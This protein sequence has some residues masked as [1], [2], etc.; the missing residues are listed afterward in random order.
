MQTKKG[1]RILVGV[2]LIVIAVLSFGY[3][4]QQKEVWFCDEIYTYES[5][6][7]FEQP[8]PATLTDRWQTGASVESYFAADW[9]R[10]SLN[11]ISIRLYCDHVPLYFW[12]FRTISVMFF[13]GSGSIW[14]GLSMNLVFYLV[15]LL[16]IYK[17]FLKL[18]DSPAVAGSVTVVS[19][20]FNRLMLEQIT[21]L[22]MYIML[23]CMMLL[24]L[25]AQLW[26]I[27]DMEKQT[28]KQKV[29]AFLLLFV[30][31]LAGFLTH[32]DFWIF[33]AVTATL[34][35]LRILV[36]AWLKRK[37]GF[38]RTKEF[39]L[40][41]AEVVDFGASLFVTTLLFPYCKWNLNRGK[42][43]LALH[44]V[45]VFSKEKLGNI[46]WGY[47]RFSEVVF[48]EIVP[49]PL[50]LLLLGG[51]MI[52]GLVI[53]GKKKEYGK[54][55]GLLLTVL[56]AQ[57]YQLAVCFTLPDAREERYLWGAYTILV[58]CACYGGYL[59]FDLFLA[60]KKLTV[61]T[62]CAVG[63]VVALCLLEY[64][65]VDGGNGVAYLNYP[66]K[67]R[68]VLSSFKDEPWVVY[69]PTG[70]VYSYYDWTIPERICFLTEENTA[71]AVACMGEVADSEELILYVYPAYYEQA[72]SFLKE[73]AN[74]DWDYE[75]VMK[76]TNYSVYRV[77]RM[78]Q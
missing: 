75:F 22:R 77:S 4:G 1:L 19:G 56:T 33:Y 12:I 76:S 34:F 5:S 51:C 36:G 74:R 72:Q 60:K 42:G 27:R 15:V 70:D 45:V 13:R 16:L 21:M 9:D 52:G 43:E 37:Q 47:K 17:T 26:I 54:L 8:W 3:W 57:G 61:R 38:F 64:L 49:V 62:C 63:L 67:D 10:L 11:D 41:I 30:V 68:K 32:Y 78:Q 40:C 44:S 24:L 25:A 29:C 73:A 58:L 53:L 7:G 20:I 66:G 46:L 14:I 2:I 69:G 48:G 18:T 35:C 50:G 28:M 39:R 6:N 59:L 71:E 65:A 31:S 55:I 23:L